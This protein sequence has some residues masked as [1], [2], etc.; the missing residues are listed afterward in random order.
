MQLSLK[1]YIDDTKSEF[2][3]ENVSTLF[4]LLYENGSSIYSDSPEE[5]RLKLRRA[6]C[7]A[8][9]SLLSDTEKGVTFIN[10]AMLTLSENCNDLN[11]GLLEEP[12]LGLL[13]I[14]L[15]LKHE[16]SRCVKEDLI[17][18]ENYLNENQGRISDEIQNKAVFLLLEYKEN[19]K[20]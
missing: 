12:Y 9:I 3:S 11:L 13:F 20:K 10:Y 6:A 7:F 14:R 16:D 18:I 17:F 2:K 5:R 1:N 15:L 4:K 19:V 8:S